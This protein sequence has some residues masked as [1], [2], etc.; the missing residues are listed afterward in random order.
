M[1]ARNT[2]KNK[3]I[4]RAV[5]E[6]NKGVQAK[7]QALQARMVELF[8]EPPEDLE[9]IEAV[10]TESLESE[11]FEPVSLHEG[12]GEQEESTNENVDGE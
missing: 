10:E 9:T 1:S 7:R 4:R 2:L 5:R 11:E 3:A 8:L 6:T 12:D